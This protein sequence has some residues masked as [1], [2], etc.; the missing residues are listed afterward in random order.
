MATVSVPLLGADFLCAFNL[1]VDVTNCCLV[2]AIS[3][4]TYPCSLGSRGHSA[5][6]TCLP[7]G[8]STNASSH[9]PLISPHLHSHQRWPSTAWSTTLPP[10]VPRSMHTL[11]AST[12]L[13]SPSPGESLPPW[14]ASALCAARTAHGP[15]PLH[16]VMKA[17]GDWRFCSDFRR[18]NNATTPDRY[19]MPHI[20]DFS[21]H[22]AG[23]TIFSKVD[24][25]H[26]YHQVPDHPQ[27]S[28]P[29][30]FVCLDDILVASASAE[31]H[32]SAQRARP[33]R[34]LS[35]VPLRPVV[36]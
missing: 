17:D 18:L 5:C 14:N 28:M 1:L 26:G 31:E 21:A 32:T 33:Q 11:C 7:L 19:P 10:P 34:Q 30:L 12:Q 4:S 22:L 8:M 3:F 16:M 24:L 20:Q 9:S 27:D 29:F 36:H 15:S 35:E 23:A 6:R 25:V 13:S 2:D